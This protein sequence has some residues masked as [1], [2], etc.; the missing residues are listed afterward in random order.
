M[1]SL[2]HFSSS[3]ARRQRIGP[4]AN[5][6]ANGFSFPMAQEA[7][8]KVKMYLSNLSGRPRNP[9][10]PRTG[11]NPTLGSLADYTKTR[12]VR[13]FHMEYY[14]LLRNGQSFSKHPG[15]FGGG[16]GPGPGSGIGSVLSTSWYMTG[17]RSAGSIMNQ[18]GLATPLMMQS[19]PQVTSH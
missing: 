1:Q 15:G 4:K 5:L 3:R 19:C 7:E 18:P 16:V 17:S 11:T 13:A 12:T 2:T 14:F 9:R 8:V 10:Q 6:V